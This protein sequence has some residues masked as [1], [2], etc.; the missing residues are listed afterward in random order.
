MRCQKTT[1]RDISVLIDSALIRCN[2]LLFLFS[3]FCSSRCVSLIPCWSIASHC[4]L[5]CVHGRS[6]YCSLRAAILNHT[7]LQ[8]CMNRYLVSLQPHH[9]TTLQLILFY[10]MLPA[11]ECTFLNVHQHYI[12]YSHDQSSC[13]LWTMPELRGYNNYNKQIGKQCIITYTVCSP[14]PLITQDN[15]KNW[16]SLRTY[17]GPCTNKEVSSFILCTS[18]FLKCNSS[19]TIL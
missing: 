18:G 4:D 14:P 1:A 15:C 16:H 2:L 19:C 9:W 5:V 8:S 10:F 13:H 3:Y 11:A 7:G 17:S 12:M 6:E